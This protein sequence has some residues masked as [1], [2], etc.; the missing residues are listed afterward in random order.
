MTHLNSSPDEKPEYTY[1]FDDVYRAE[2]DYVVKRREKINS[3]IEPLESDS[4]IEL[5]TQIQFPTK[6]VEDKNAGEDSCTVS[7][8]PPQS[9]LNR[10]KD[11]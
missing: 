4:K 7:E 1:D 11:K 2:L 6:D 10:L 8:T 3:L 9:L 5:P